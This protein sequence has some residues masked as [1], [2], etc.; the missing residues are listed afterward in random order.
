MRPPFGCPLRGGRLIFFAAAVAAG[1]ARAEAPLASSD[2]AAEGL[3]A[4]RF[5]R[6][7]EFAKNLVASGDYLGVV[8]L[9]ARGG[10][11]VDWRANGHRDLART[12]PMRPDTIFRIY[13]MTK[14]VVS[15]AMLILMEEGR[16]ASL[17]DA[18]GKY[19]PA[20][21][22]RPI[23]LRHLLTSSRAASWKRYRAGASRRSFA[24]ASSRRCGCMTPV[25]LFLPTSARES[26]K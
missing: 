3:S 1:A 4:Q 8:T 22:G 18:V 17:E 20:F 26:R 11:I 10:R 24:S 6:V 12:A 19:L 13:S 5:E 15:V 16:I 2:P 7:R 9:V 25:S 23:T 21:A 14:P